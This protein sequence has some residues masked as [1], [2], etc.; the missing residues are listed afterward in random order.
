[1]LAIKILDFDLEGSHFIIEADISLRQKIDDNTQIQWPRYLLENTQVY[2]ETDGVVSPF[3]ITAV[4][5]YG[6]QLTADHALEDVLERITRNETGKLTVHDV[7]PE[8]Q[9]FLDEFKKYPAINGERTVPYF[10]F[11]RGEI[12]R[13]AYATN[14]FLYYADSNDMPVM[15]RTD[16]GTLISDNEFAD[17]GL[18]DSEQR[19]EKGAEH[20]LPFTEYESDILSTWN[21]EKEAYLD[22]LLDAFVDKNDLEDEL[23]L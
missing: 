20:L 14:R 19:V 3:P 9:E 6:C 8:L 22:S 2:K 13:L 16:D 11:H 10:I 17:I 7:C 4:T 5:W 1:M 12:A 18:Y 23:P 21:L 15:F